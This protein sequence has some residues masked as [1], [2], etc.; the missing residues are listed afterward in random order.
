LTAT[1]ALGDT[2]TDSLYNDAAIRVEI[3]GT[4]YWIPLY[5]G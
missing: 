5:N 2:D 3:G 1:H 4:A